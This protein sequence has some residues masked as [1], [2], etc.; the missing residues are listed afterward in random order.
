MSKTNRRL[1]GAISGLAVLSA[2]LASGAAASVPVELRVASSDAGNLADVIQYVPETTTVKTYSGPDCFNSSKQSSGKSYT[3]SSP[4]MLSAIWEASQAEPALQPVRLTDADYANFGALGV[5]QINAKSEPGFAYFNLR[6]N[7]NAI[8]VGA[9]LFTVR[10]GEDLV[11][12]RTPSDGTI[13][14][15][16]DLGAPVRT[17]P[18]SVVVNV[19]AYNATFGDPN[20]GAVEFRP[21]IVVSG[22]DAPAVTDK[23]GNA[24]VTL[25]HT[26]TYQLVATGAYND[27]PSPVLSVCVQAQPEREC[28]DERGLE[29][30]GSDESDGIKGTDG[31]DTIK[32]RDGNDVIKAGAGD[33]LIVANGGGRDR[34]YCGGGRDTVMRDKKDKVSK[35]CEV[36]RPRVKGKKHGK[37]KHGKHKK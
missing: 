25:S 30:L 12:Y 11:A 36:V 22:G 20:N 28:P 23:N 21:G 31:N 15:E 8:P 24:L 26:G 1:L 2:I 33:D 34:I 29:I 35:N 14:A 18:G 16:L 27:I 7:H 32:A 5:C 3:E 19:R 4:N 10:G 17:T 13:G 6:A 37:H 9:D